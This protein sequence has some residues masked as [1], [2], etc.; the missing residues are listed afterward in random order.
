MTEAG[1]MIVNLDQAEAIIAEELESWFAPTFWSGPG[2]AAADG[3]T[4]AS[5]LRRTIE[6][7]PCSREIDPKG[8]KTP[9]GRH[10]PV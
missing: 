3:Q 2:C 9:A 10:P 8:R 6:S 4:L 7:L 1:E 5:V